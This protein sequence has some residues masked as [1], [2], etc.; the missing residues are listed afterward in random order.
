MINIY[1]INDKYLDYLKTY[2]KHVFRRIF[3]GPVLSINDIDY[4][5]PIYEDIGKSYNDFHISTRVLL[6]HMI[7]A[8]QFVLCEV[9]TSRDSD[10]F[11]LYQKYE[12]DLREIA[13]RIYKSII[14]GTHRHKE[15]CCNLPLLESIYK[16]FP[17]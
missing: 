11:T 5:A 15:R 1:F 7:P 8:P 9:P 3:C 10:S 4:Y 12:A 17:H 16:D 13:E 6:D 14:Y 2:D